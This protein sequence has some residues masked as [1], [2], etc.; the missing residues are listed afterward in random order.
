MGVIHKG[1]Q[2]TSKELAM[3][4]SEAIKPGMLMSIDT[5]GTPD[6]WAKHASEG[7]NAQPFFADAAP[8]LATDAT[9][10]VDSDVIVGILGGAGVRVRGI[11]DQ[12][13]TVKTGDALQSGAAAGT[14]RKLV[15]G[16]NGGVVGTEIAGGSA[17]DHTVTAIALGDRLV[18]VF[19]ISTKASIATLDDITSEF[20]VLAGKIN[21]DGGTDTASDQLMI[22]YEDASAAAVPGRIV[23]YADERVTTGSSENKNINLWTV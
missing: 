20:S 12:N 22:F 14:L 15:V 19:H 23:G 17:G 4:D 21:N 11:L 8:H 9:A 2:F 5:G 10:Y 13:E 1:G 16:N 6:E 18:A 3:K 7:G